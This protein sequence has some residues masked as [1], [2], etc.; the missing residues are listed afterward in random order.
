MMDQV[1]GVLVR[2]NHVEMGGGRKGLAAQGNCSP[3]VGKRL[4]GA[5][6]NSHRGPE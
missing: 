5:S 4:E 3:A 2:K 1:L 6:W